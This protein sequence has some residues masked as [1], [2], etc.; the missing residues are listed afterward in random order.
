MQGVE[1]GGPW[2]MRILRDVL[3]PSGVFVGGD[4]AAKRLAMLTKEELI[5]GRFP[6]DD[7]S[8]RAGNS[9]TL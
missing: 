4:M 7:S 1:R 9:L 5:A 3:G 6:G 2:S 8:S